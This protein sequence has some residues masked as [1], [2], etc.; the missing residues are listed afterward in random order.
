MPSL[1]SSH[2]LCPTSLMKIRPVPGCTA[3]VNGLRRPSAQ[4]ARLAPVAV[5]KNGL[6]EGIVP[7]GLIRSILPWRVV[8]DVAFAE[9]ALSPTAT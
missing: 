2:A 8:M 9:F 5:A 1:I 6:S 4:M 7:S 3:N